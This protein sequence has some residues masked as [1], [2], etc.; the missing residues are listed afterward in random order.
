MPQWLR[1]IF[2]FSM[3]AF[4][5]AAPIK[6]A[7]YWQSHIK[8][9]HAVHEDVLYRSG[10]MTLVGLKDVLQDYGINTVVTLRDAKR[11]GEMPPDQDEEDYCRSQGINYYRISPPAW[12]APDGSVPAEAAVKQFLAVMDRP[13]NYPV[14][15]HC[16]AGIHRTGA[17]CAVFRMEY[18]HWSNEQAIDE[19]RAQGYTNLPDEWDILTYLENYQP[20]WQTTQPVATNPHASVEGKPVRWTKQPTR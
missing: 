17:F 2:A 4:I 7:L 14:L 8:N 13:E 20:R 3:F 15:I 6:Y 5:V 1:L 11:A 10:Q 18:E 19:L 16:F 9:F 12:L